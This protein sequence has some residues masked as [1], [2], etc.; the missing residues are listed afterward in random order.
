MHLKWCI[1]DRPASRV[2]LL[3]ISTRFSTR[4]VENPV[5]I[6]VEQSVTAKKSTSNRSQ[7]SSLLSQLLSRCGLPLCIFYLRGTH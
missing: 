4:A 5:E 3:Q 1:A 6:L 7:G 2:A